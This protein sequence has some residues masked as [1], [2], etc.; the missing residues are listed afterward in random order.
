MAESVTSQFNNLA[1]EA[2][3]HAKTL[4]EWFMKGGR[5]DIETPGG[6][7]TTCNRLA[8]PMIAQSPAALCSLIAALEANPFSPIRTGQRAY[9]DHWLSMALSNTNTLLQSSK[10]ATEVFM[11]V[12]FLTWI[13]HHMG[14]H[15]AL[16]VHISGYAALMAC[17][18]DLFCST[19]YFRNGP[20][21]WTFPSNEG[22]ILPETRTPPEHNL[23]TADMEE[24]I[25]KSSLMGLQLVGSVSSDLVLFLPHLLAMQ[26]IIPDKAGQ[27]S[28]SSAKDL[29]TYI[30]FNSRTLTSLEDLAISRLESCVHHACVIIYYA[31]LWRNP[32]SGVGWLVG[33]IQAN[34]T[35]TDLAWLMD[36]YAEV[37]LWFCL[38]GG[39]FAKD[40]AREWWLD[41]LVSVR[42]AMHVGSFEEARQTMEE[43]LLWTRWLD[44]AAEAFWN[45][46]TALMRELRLP[47]ERSPTP[48]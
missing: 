21:F 20:F 18:W 42:H 19:P 1:V 46:T 11:C 27:L 37:L 24:Q 15:Q 4:I 34:I 43:K 39:H 17:H 48:S 29:L 12:S 36:E 2:D 38:V 16:R 25:S 31:S 30:W 28:I 40:F 32:G 3:P 8:F 47:W 44:Q 26:A 6:R 14:D 7:L 10:A 33:S 22:N 13:A 23:P 35:T 41:L 45:E 9:R 5:G